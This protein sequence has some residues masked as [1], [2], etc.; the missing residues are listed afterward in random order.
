MSRNQHRRHIHILHC[1]AIC[2]RERQHLVVNI[3]V[4]KNLIGISQGPAIKPALAERPHP[5]GRQIVP[6]AIVAVVGGPQ[7]TGERV[8]IQPNGIAQTTGVDPPTGTVG[9]KNQDRGTF[10][11]VVAAQIA[12]RTHIQK[13]T[14]V[15]WI[16]NNGLGHMTSPSRAL[17][18]GQV[19]YKN[20]ALFIKSIAVAVP[21]TVHLVGVG[22]VEIAL[23][24]RQAVHPP[25]TVGHHQ[26]GIGHPVLVAVGQGDNLA[27]RTVRR[28]RPLA[29][30]VDFH[31]GHVQHTVRTPGHKA[32]PLQTIGGKDARLKAGRQ[33]KLHLVA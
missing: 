29:G 24:K 15:G 6:A 3:K 1:Q 11:I 22:H 16:K 26:Q 23:V 14:F 25:K 27:T 30:A 21:H 28:R 18:G 2:G 7:L 20:F 10:G 4:Y 17:K 19:V 9:I 13:E 8:Q 31:I 12:G 33:G 32:R 5:F